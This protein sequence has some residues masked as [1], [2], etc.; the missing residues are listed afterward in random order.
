MGDNDKTTSNEDCMTNSSRNSYQ[1][2]LSTQLTDQVGRTHLVKVSSRVREQFRLPPDPTTPEWLDLMWVVRGVVTGLMPSAKIRTR[3]GFAR[4]AEFCSLTAGSADPVDRRIAVQQTDERTVQVFLPEELAQPTGKRLVLLVEDDPDLRQLAQMMIA[5]AG[6]EV[7]EAADGLA[8]LQLAQSHCPSVIVTDVDM[9]RLNGLQLCR[10]IKTT[11]QTKS[12]SVLVW[13][14]N[15]D[16]EP[17]ALQA[18]AAGFIGKPVN[19]DHFIKLLKH[20]LNH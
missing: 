9:P 2:I 3:T 18:G 1:M 6:Y 11:A 8:G 5:S 16:N 14:G 20:H 12:I 4:V 13:S 10:Q 7:L 17:A 19:F 15:S